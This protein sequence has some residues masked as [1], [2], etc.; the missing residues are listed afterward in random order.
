MANPVKSAPPAEEKQLTMEEAQVAAAVEKVKAEEKAKEKPARPTGGTAPAG[1]EGEEAVKTVQLLVFTLDKEEYATIITDVREITE[2]TKVTEVPNAPTFI[3][4]I[5]NLRGKVVVVVNLEERFRLVREHLEIKPEHI[6]IIEIGEATFGVIVDEVTE[7]LRIPEA[8]IKEAPE[9]I[10]SKIRADYLS[11]VGLVEERLILLLDFKK[12]LSEKE[13]ADLSKLAEFQQKKIVKP[14][15]EKEKKVDIEKKIKELAAKKKVTKK[16][17]KVAA[18]PEEKPVEKE[19]VEEEPEETETE[20]PTTP[21]G[22]PA[23]P[24]EEEEKKEET[25]AEPEPGAEEEETEA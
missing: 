7:V 3:G 5:I 20:E 11:G 14:P 25:P 21:A 15:E 13:L 16:G 2:I 19:E 4:G 6:I 22:G 1:V 10:S 8:N 18:E 24:A 9:I 17:G 23:E 12:V